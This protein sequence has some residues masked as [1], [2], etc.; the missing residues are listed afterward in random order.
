MDRVSDPVLAGC[1]QPRL[2][3]LDGRIGR[4]RY[5]AFTFF[6]MVI[7]VLVSGVVTTVISPLLTE[8]GLA[9][10]SL[11]LMIVFNLPVLI[12][13]L[14]M[15]KRRLNDLDHPS[16]LALAMMVPAV[17]FFFGIYLL[18]A[19]GSVRSNRYGLPPTKNSVW[20]VVAAL[21]LPTIVVIG[22]VTAMTLPD[23]QQYIPPP[24]QFITSI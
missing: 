24:S 13:S 20:M 1:Y 2:F 9:D 3:S 22:I 17:N 11:L 16:W 8:N 14:V 19:S 12:V 10:S 4:L 6:S 21:I 5:L 7:V 18:F 23:Y 15:A